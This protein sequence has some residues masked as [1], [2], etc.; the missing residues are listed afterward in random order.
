[1]ITS[2]NKENFESIIQM[3]QELLMQQKSCEVIKD[4]KSKHNHQKH[5]LKEQYQKQG[6]EAVL[7]RSHTHGY[8]NDVFLANINNFSSNKS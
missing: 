7:L 8:D 5:V 1:M 3:Q 6:E 2:T 4:R